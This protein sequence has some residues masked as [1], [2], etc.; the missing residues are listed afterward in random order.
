MLQIKNLNYSIGDRVLLDE[1][2]WMIQPGKRA[3]LIGPNGVG[4]TTLLRILTDEIEY[5]KG[6]I[7]KPKEYLIGYLPQEE[8]AVKG[9]SILQAVLEGQKEIKLLEQKIA[10]LHETLTQDHDNHEALLEQLGMLEHRFQ[11]MDGYHLETQ[12][13][14]ILSG[15]GFKKDDFARSLTEFSGGWRMRVYLALLLVLKPDLLLLDEPTNHLDLP[16]LEWLEQYLMTFSG[17]IIA[18]SHDRFFVDRLAQEIVELERGKFQIYP[19][20]YH[21][22]E[23]LKTQKEELHL[24]KWHEQKVEREKQERFINRFRYKNTKAKAVQSRIRQLEKMSALEVAPPTQFRP[25]LDFTLSVDVASYNDVLSIKDMSFKY[26]KEWVLENNDLTIFR[27][28]K[29]SLVGPNGVGKTTLT[30]LISNQLQPQKGSIQLGERVKIGYYAQHQ[31]DALDL[32]ATV[33]EEI[34]STVATSL[35]PKLRSVLGI[36]QFSGNDV[37]KKIGVLS[38]GEKARV[39]LAKIL[40]SPVNFL[41]MDE[42][43][44]HLDKFAKEALEK[45][46]SQYNGTLLLISHDRYFLDKIVNRVIEIRDHHLLEFNGNYSYF[47]QKRDSVRVLVPGTSTDPEAQAPQAGN[48]ITPQAFPEGTKKTKEQKRLEASARQAVS[49]ERNVMKRAVESLEEKIEDFETKKTDL[50]ARLS[51]QETYDNSQLAVT[52]QKEYANVI[53]DLEISTTEWEKAITTLEELESK[54]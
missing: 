36:F 11:A 43:T 34:A 45:A 3:A 13:K 28:D 7:I 23:K 54:I 22:Y 51:Q 27:G 52:L 35:I 17:S 41:I 32:E 2:D 38:G 24:K 46:L 16:S 49:K 9:T 42:P 39:S 48:P 21:T 30:R 6:S 15:L 37:Y 10:D 18:V 53:K 26:D 20:N 25:E 8:V 47:L 12:A 19:G 5:S 33:Y 1:A 14:S 40:I 29:V 50:E 44:N 4:K 31:V